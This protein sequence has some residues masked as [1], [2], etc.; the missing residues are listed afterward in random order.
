MAVCFEVYSE[1][2]ACNRAAIFAPPMAHYTQTL[3]QTFEIPVTKIPERIIIQCT[4]IVMHAAI[5]ACSI[6]FLQRPRLLRMSHLTTN[7]H[8]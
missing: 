3:L 2:C 8:L 5:S 4:A 7:C 6:F 1:L